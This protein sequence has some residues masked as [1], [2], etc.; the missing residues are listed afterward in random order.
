MQ[1]CLSNMKRIVISDRFKS[2][3]ETNNLFH[4]PFL[5]F[6]KQHGDL[7][8]N[9]Q[10]FLNGLSGNI[11]NETLARAKITD[12]RTRFMI[13]GYLQEKSRFPR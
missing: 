7:W 4:V 13:A 3:V 1:L 6:P 12:V 11:K 8:K 5:K 9:A 2:K 10:I